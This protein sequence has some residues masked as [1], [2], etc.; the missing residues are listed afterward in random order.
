MRLPLITYVPCTVHLHVP[1][2]QRYFVNVRMVKRI[3]GQEFLILEL[4]RLTE[5]CHSLLAFMNV[6]PW[7]GPSE[8]LRHIWVFL[9][10]AQI[11]KDIGPDTY[12]VE[13]AVQRA[14]DVQRF[15]MFLP[16]L[17]LAALVLWSINHLKRS[18]A[19]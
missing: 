7:E 12:E 6:Y 9:E 14:I 17:I 11:L 15:L 1:G 2:T 8:R 3:G 10:K 4:H 18:V 19:M 5:S 13:D 16:F